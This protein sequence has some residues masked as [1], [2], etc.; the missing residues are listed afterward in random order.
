MARSLKFKASYCN[1]ECRQLYGNSTNDG[2]FCLAGYTQNPSTLEGVNNVLKN[3][4]SVCSR[5][6]SFKKSEEAKID[7]KGKK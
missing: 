1:E 4:G 6:R 2:K 5:A 3:K 7:R